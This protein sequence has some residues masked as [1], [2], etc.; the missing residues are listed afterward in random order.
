MVLGSRDHVK[1]TGTRY[2]IW[3]SVH[4]NIVPLDLYN[5]LIT[6]DIQI[7]NK[8]EISLTTVITN[9]HEI[10]TLF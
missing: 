4:V 10:L 3:Y 1:Y 5:K 9:K 2:L 7:T 6:R 8:H